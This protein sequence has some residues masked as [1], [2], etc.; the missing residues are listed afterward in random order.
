MNFLWHFLCTDFRF[1]RTDIILRKI[2]NIA[3]L[4]LHYLLTDS[5]VIRDLNS[6]FGGCYEGVKNLEETSRK[7]HKTKNVT[8]SQKRTKNKLSRLEKSRIN[9]LI[10]YITKKFEFYNSSFYTSKWES[11]NDDPFGQK[12]NLHTRKL[13]WLGDLFIKTKENSECIKVKA[14]LNI[15]KF[16]PIP[17]LRNKQL[18]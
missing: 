2:L 18:I 7:L 11:V 14:F 17:P 15:Y 4:Y 12:T 9:W 13:C 1:R 5:K 3:F 10:T 8:Y 16:H 6:S